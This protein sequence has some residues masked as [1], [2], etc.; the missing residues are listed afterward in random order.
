VDGGWKRPFIPA[1]IIPADAWATWP[2]GHDN[3]TWLWGQVVTH[4]HATNQNNHS[5]IAHCT[6]VSISRRYIR[7]V[8]LFYLLPSS[9][10]S[11]DRRSRDRRSLLRP[12][13]KQ[14]A[15]NPVRIVAGERVT[16]LR[17]RS[18]RLRNYDFCNNITSVI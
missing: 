12:L 17:L 8:S 9:S 10:A 1:G 2:V 3:N 5:V 14:S 4:P 6:L 15:V 18:K 11:R 13:N 16:A 7:V